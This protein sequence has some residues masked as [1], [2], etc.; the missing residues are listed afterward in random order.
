MARTTRVLA[1]A[2]VALGLSAMLATPALARNT[3]N[4]AQLTLTC[5]GETHQI[6][7]AGNGDWS[8]GRDNDTTIVFHPTAFGEITRTFYP[9]DG[10]PSQTQTDAPNQ[11]KAQQQSGHPRLDCSFLYDATYPSGRQVDTGDVSGWI[12]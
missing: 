7:I 5:D 9:A 6:T 11:F 4:K 12:S 2:V 10:S 1:L 8:P 3:G